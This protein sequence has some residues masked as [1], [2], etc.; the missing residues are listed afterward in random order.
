MIP[1]LHAIAFASFMALAAWQQLHARGASVVLVYTGVAAA[2]SLRAMASPEAH[3][4][5]L[6]GLLAAL[7]VVMALMAGRL[8]GGSELRLLLLVGAFLGPRHTVTAVLVT[9]GVMLLSVGA[10]ALLRRGRLGTTRAARLLSEPQGGLGW[11][12]GQ[13]VVAAEGEAA[14]AAAPAAL[15]S[16]GVAI[17][18]GAV[19]GWIL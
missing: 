16:P 11:G 10:G 7:L 9:L 12:G 18:V 5:G 6:L 1:E 2:L 14:Q 8:A 19:A 4:E 13:L 17:V 3:M 15:V